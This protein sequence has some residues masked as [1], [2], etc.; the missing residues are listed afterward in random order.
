M[1]GFAILASQE[2]TPLAGCGRGASHGDL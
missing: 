2:H 1:V